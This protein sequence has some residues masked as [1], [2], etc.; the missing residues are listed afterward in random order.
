MT[1]RVIRRG[2]AVVPGDCITDTQRTPATPSSDTCRPDFTEPSGTTVIL[3]ATRAESR[4]C[5]RRPRR[6]GCGA[7][8]RS[9]QEAATA[10]PPQTWAKGPAIRPFS[11]DLG[12]SLL[13]SR[14]SVDREIHHPLSGLGRPIPRVESASRRGPKRGFDGPRI[15]PTQ[16]LTRLAARAV[17]Q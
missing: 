1:R 7:G 10:S 14:I 12:P 8:D 11:R 4:R 15:L 17:R 9:Q 13:T 5:R 6:S 3:F 16:T 2:T